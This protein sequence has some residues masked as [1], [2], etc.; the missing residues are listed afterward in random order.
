M[1]ALTE[2]SNSREK[3][4]G[5]L[6]VESPEPKTPFADLHRC[7]SAAGAAAARRHFPDHGDVDLA[8]FATKVSRRILQNRHIGYNETVKS[9]ADLLGLGLAAGHL[10]AP[11]IGTYCRVPGE[12][13]PVNDSAANAAAIDVAH[14]MKMHWVKDFLAS[15]F[16]RELLGDPLSRVEQFAGA[17]AAHRPLGCQHDP[18][19]D[20]GRVEREMVRLAMDPHGP[21]L[22]QSQ[23]VR[24][25]AFSIDRGV[26]LSVSANALRYFPDSGRLDLEEFTR[27]LYRSSLAAYLADYNDLAR[28][29]ARLI[30]LHAP[31]EFFSMTTSGLFCVPPEAVEAAHRLAMAEALEEHMMWMTLLVAS[32][33]LRSADQSSIS[34]PIFD[35]TRFFLAALQ[36]LAPSG[37][38]ADCLHRDPD[39]DSTED[40]AVKLVL[41]RF[42]T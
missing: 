32:E 37:C 7:W 22:M 25:V 42:R 17:V 10:S 31:D 4:L 5:L 34:G 9:K 1:F 21:V 26:A 15:A 19:A 13:D 40:R 3:E 14:T 23:Q 33:L 2:F 35:R 36:L 27:Q 41:H 8:R 16:E 18:T 29:I 20:H 30:G 12:L 6:P 11:S 38:A 39:S 24:E 28:V